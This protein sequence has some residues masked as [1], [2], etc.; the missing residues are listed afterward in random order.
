MQ[1]HMLHGIQE[2]MNDWKESMIEASRLLKPDR[3]SA[4]TL[5]DFIFNRFIVLLNTLLGAGFST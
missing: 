2:Q 1:Q 3:M 5:N 4:L